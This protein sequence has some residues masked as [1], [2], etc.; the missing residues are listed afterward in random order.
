MELFAVKRGTPLP[1]EVFERIIRKLT[2]NERARILQ[3]RKWEDR[4]S[5]LLGN[6]LIKK[7][8]EKVLKTPY[9]GIV[10][11]RDEWGRPFVEG[12][13]QWEGDFNLSHS[14]E[15]IVLG[16]VNKGRIGIDIELIHPI[17]LTISEICF[18]KEERY[19]LEN[20][21][22]SEQLDFFYEI[23]TLKEAFVKA[24]GR[25][26]SYPLNSFGFDVENWGNNVIDLKNKNN[27]FEENSFFQ[28]HKLDSIYQL[29]VC[30]SYQKSVDININL[31]KRTLLLNKF[32]D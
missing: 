12:F 5:S 2:F 29:A 4:Q 25:G 9:D 1:N 7:Y 18:T 6:I 17:D 31:V 13:P 10:L 3:F 20:I 28:L 16:V 27:R 22:L 11:N 19:H 24:I 23:W 14:G 30:T 26:L 8:L 21:S 32:I 15:W